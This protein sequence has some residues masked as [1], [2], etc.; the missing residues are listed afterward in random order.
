MTDEGRGIGGTVGPPWSVDVLADLHAGVLEEWEAA[1]LWPLVNADSGALAIIKALEAT[2]AD[3]AGLAA[4][5]VEP[6]PAG[7]ATRLD[8]AIEN[9]VIENAARQPP[10]PAVASPASLDAARSRRNTRLG[11]GAGLLARLRP[12]PR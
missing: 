11:W 6:M 3:L 4:A 10:R 12:P 5:L 1:E 7:V 9:F 2:T 8:V